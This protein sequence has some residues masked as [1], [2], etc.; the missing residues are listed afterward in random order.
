MKI[1][2]LYGDHHSGKT[3]TLN[4]VFIS[5]QNKTNVVARKSKHLPKNDIEYTFDY[6]GKHIA[7]ESAGDCREFVRKTINK[8]HNTIPVD[9]LII[10]YNQQMK[11]IYSNILEADEIHIVHKSNNNLKFDY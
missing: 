2:I 9:V 1:I 5:L 10:A 7:L 4:D 8:Y 6:N 3:Q 11:T